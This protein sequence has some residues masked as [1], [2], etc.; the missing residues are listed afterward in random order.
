MKDSNIKP[1]VEIYE[2]STL[3]KMLWKIHKTR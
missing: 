2:F 3:M 1:D